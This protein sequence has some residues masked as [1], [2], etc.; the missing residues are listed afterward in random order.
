M[1]VVGPLA[2]FLLAGLFWGI[3]VV[4]EEI[5]PSLG[6]IV[7]EYLAWINVALGV[8]NLFPGFPLDGGRVFRAFW[9]W[10]TG[11][12]RRATRL[13]SD[14]GKG[15]AL[16]LIILGGLE[17]FAGALLGGLWFIF[18]GMF[19]RG[20]AEGGYQGLILKQS[21]EAVEAREIMV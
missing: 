5:I 20:M 9:W 7:L 18:I 21:L 3:K 10:K 11:S 13:A 19:L 1:A 8:F 4:F 16:T 15:L 12:L 14:M 6:V 17:I 2:S